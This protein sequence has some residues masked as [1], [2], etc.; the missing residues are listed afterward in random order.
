MS[1]PGS[2]RQDWMELAIKWPQLSKGLLAKGGR[3]CD[4]V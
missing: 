1:F 2:A 4:D 3:Y